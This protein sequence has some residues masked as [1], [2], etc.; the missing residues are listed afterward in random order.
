[1][2]DYAM[3]L[4]MAVYG[5]GAGEITCLRFDSVD[6]QHQKLRVVR[7]KNNT[8]I[9]LPLLPAVAKALATYLEKGRPPL[10]L[11]RALFVSHRNPYR[12]ISA[13]SAIRHRII[14]HASR[15]GVHADY[16]GSHV[17]RHSHATRQI[18]LGA[19][20]KTVSDILG[21]RR[22]ESTS[23]YVRTATKRLR[24]VALPVPR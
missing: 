12:A 17:F 23:I 16:L 18:E 15:A 8:P 20:P 7:P 10:S 24:S 9:A 19:P 4:M 22:P 21:H 5:L 14:K 6:W 11:S 3:F 13:S 1:M 2:R